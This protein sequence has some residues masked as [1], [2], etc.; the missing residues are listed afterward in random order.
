MS[1]VNNILSTPFDSQPAGNR[2][3]QPDA[4]TKRNLA[5][6]VSYAQAQARTKGAPGKVNSTGAKQNETLEVVRERNK[7]QAQARNVGRKF[8][9]HV[10]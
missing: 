7:G 9:N 6:R 8:S 2:D 3:K 4:A 5:Q 10:R 1:Q